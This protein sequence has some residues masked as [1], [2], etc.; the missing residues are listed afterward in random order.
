MT[1]QHDI[2]CLL[3]G[4]FVGKFWNWRNLR[5]VKSLKAI[6]ESIGR[7]LRMKPMISDQRIN[8]LMPDGFQSM[9]RSRLS[10]TLYSLPPTIRTKNSKNHLALDLA[11]GYYVLPS[12]HDMRSLIPFIPTTF[13]FEA[14]IPQTKGL[15]GRESTHEWHYINQTKEAARRMWWK[16]GHGGEHK[17][18]S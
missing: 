5:Y 17:K 11:I 16:W 10:C 7:A 12:V 2:C 8:L 18:D 3:A 14:N 9:F 4:L 6:W 15:F 1:C 13:L